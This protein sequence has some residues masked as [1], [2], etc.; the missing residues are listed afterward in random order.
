MKLFIAGLDT[1]TNTFAPIPTGARAFAEG[2]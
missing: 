1:E 2:F